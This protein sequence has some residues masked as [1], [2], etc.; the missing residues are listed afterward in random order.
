MLNDNIKALILS[1]I[2]LY[3]NSNLNQ[4]AINNGINKL[5]QAKQLLL[6]QDTDLALE[7]TFGL[8]VPDSEVPY[9]DIKIA[10]DDVI[11]MEVGDDLGMVAHL[12]PHE[13]SRTNP[14]K[15]TTSNKDIV[16]VDGY[17]LTAKKVG[18]ATITTTTL[19]GLYSDSITVNVTEPYEFIPTE[20]EIYFVEPDRFNLI[21]HLEEHDPYDQNIAFT[22]SNAIKSIFVYA[23]AK[24]YKKVVF[25]KNQ[26]YYY[27][28]SFKIYLKNDLIIDLNGST[29]QIYPNYFYNCTGIHFEENIKMVDVCPRGWKGYESI[30]NVRYKDTYWKNE[31]GGWVWSY[32]EKGGQHLYELNY[33][34]GGESGEILLNG[35]IPVVN[36]WSLDEYNQYRNF[37]EKDKTYK[38]YFSFIKHR[39]HDKI[40]NVYTNNKIIM[41]M[42]CYKNGELINSIDVSTFSWNKNYRSGNLNFEFT[43]N[44]I[45]CDS[46]SFKVS[47]LSDTLNPL[48][49]AVTDLAIYEKQ[50]LP[51]NYRNMIIDNGNILGDKS[52]KDLEGNEL[53]TSLFKT[54]YGQDWRSIASTEGSMNMELSSGYHSGCTNLTIGDTCGFNIGV[55]GGKIATSYYKNAREFE[56]GS[57]D[58]FGNKINKESYARSST[59]YKV[60]M[61]KTPYFIITDPT[62][63]VTYY[64]GFR[65]RILDVYYYDKDMNFIKCVKGK[66][67]HGLLRAPEGTEYINLAIPL[68]TDE[69]LP[70]AGHSDFG[71]CILSIK[72]IYPT[73]KCFF[74]NCEIKNN[75]SCGMAHSGM[76][77]LVE[78]CNFHDNIG[79]MPWA[80]V[81]S[82][83]GWVRMQNNVFRNNSF[84]SYYGFI[85]CSG[86]NYV[87]KNNTFNCPVKLWGDTQYYKVFG[88]TFN[89]KG[90]I[91]AGGLSSM[92]DMYISN[93]IFDNVPV[94]SD[95]KHKANYRVYYYNNIFDSC[96]LA[97]NDS[98]D[99]NNK[100]TGD[101]ELKTS[102]TVSF[103]NNKPKEYFKDV[104][105]LGFNSTSTC[106][107]SDFNIAKVRI[108]S[109][110][111]I[112]FNNCILKALPTAYS[113]ASLGKS[114]FNNCTIYNSKMSNS[115][116]YN[117]CNLIDGVIDEYVVEGITKEGLVFSQ[118]EANGIYKCLQDTNL[119]KGSGSWSIVLLNTKI[120]NYF[121]RAV[122][123]DTF[124]AGVG[125]P[126]TGVDVKI[127]RT[128][129]GGV[130]SSRHMWSQ[131]T[132][133]NPVN[134]KNSY[135]FSMTYNDE[136][137]TYK[138]YINTKL[139]YTYAIPN[140]YEP[141]GTK[142]VNVWGQGTINYYY[143][144]DKLLTDEELNNNIQILMNLITE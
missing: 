113:G 128:N 134:G 50:T 27:D 45:D 8:D 109:N 3:S 139:I 71:N 144:Y 43:L 89:N 107:N 124:E 68:V 138:L 122:S 16:D 76:G 83:D 70:T 110:A 19:N 133:S 22:N 56:L 31:N 29:L 25:P 66:F 21:A 20:N 10:L 18:S 60:D 98:V 100:L 30:G 126:G 36:T 74:K 103:I 101:I 114:I 15:L 88:N 41:T 38:G 129:D 54:L 61:T 116:T 121:S 14:F 47:G 62:F 44:D 125:A 69:A 73:E 26:I 127:W 9:N 75:Y 12:L 115:F 64:F 24:G 108:K 65:S 86:T 90:Y 59:M 143:H 55:G 119:T 48:D 105:S 39:Q 13:W 140:G 2:E 40:D 57:F 95:T 142:N 49:V 97:L 1:V 11:E 17:I 111:T 99:A 87:L 4:N 132:N 51:S 106:E 136:T 35:D 63:I 141:L 81:D 130:T 123:S 85:M 34:K 118:K 42:L 135:V 94:N 92:S 80:D 112:T 67:R 102:N 23:K 46:I 93:N 120:Y 52:L 77:V 6:E 82:E 7:K 72:T 58:D 137:K 78:N 79:R 131:N 104:L 84:N 117:D 37:I 5:K 33:N 96:Y 91:G 32:T 53:K 28:P